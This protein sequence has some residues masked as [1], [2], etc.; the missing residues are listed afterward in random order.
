MVYQTL[1]KLN[2]EARILHIDY[3]WAP[4]ARLRYWDD[5]LA[6]GPAEIGIVH[7]GYGLP[8]AQSIENYGESLGV[9]TTFTY[10]AQPGDLSRIGLELVKFLDR[11]SA[12]EAQVVVCVDSLSLM[13]QYASGDTVMNFL[14]ELYNKLE[15]YDALGRIY[16]TPLAHSQ[17]VVESIRAE[18]TNS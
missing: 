6:E 5:E 10:V 17:Q 11:V 7:T 2:P 3:V 13:L 8:D 4:K 12:E 15:Y 16:F 9:K 14:T 18:L 1:P